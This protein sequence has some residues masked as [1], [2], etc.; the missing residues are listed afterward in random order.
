MN[1]FTYYSK[2]SHS[3]NVTFINVIS[4]VFISIVV[5]STFARKFFVRKFVNM[6]PDAKRYKEETS[7]TDKQQ[8]QVGPA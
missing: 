1:D 3:C 5:V 4:K 2:K 8:I 6:E 7:R